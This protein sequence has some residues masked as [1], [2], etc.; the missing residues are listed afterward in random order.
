MIVR[1]PPEAKAN[2]IGTRQ[3]KRSANMPGMRNRKPEADA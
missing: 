1:N 3:L 2:K